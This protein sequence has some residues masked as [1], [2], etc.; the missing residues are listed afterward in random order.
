MSKL[1]SDSRLLYNNK[2]VICC[3]Y[4]VI[5][6]FCFN[7]DFAKKYGLQEA[8][9]FEIIQELSNYSTSKYYQ[10]K[11]WVEISDY[12]YQNYWRFLSRDEFDFAIKKLINLKIIAELEID[13]VMYYSIIK[14]Q[15]S[16]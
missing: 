12:D 13:E 4:E 3:Q 1:I 11:I 15:S 9:V 14:K 2:S 16:F 7:S 8:I 10:D 6:I 5:D